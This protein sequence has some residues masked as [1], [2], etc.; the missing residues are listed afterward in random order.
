[1]PTHKQRKIRKIKKEIKRKIQNKQRSATAGTNNKTNNKMEDMLKMIMLMRNGQQQQST[2]AA[3]ELLTAKEM[4][5]KQQQEEARKQRENK[6]EISK[7]ELNNKIEDA[8]AKTQETNQTLEQTRKL[9]EIYKQIYEAEANLKNAKNELEIRK[10]QEKLNALNQQMEFENKTLDLMIQGQGLSENQ[11]ELK[12]EIEEKRGILKQKEV[13]RENKIQQLDIKNMESEKKQVEDKLLENISTIETLAKLTNRTGQIYKSVIND[14]KEYLKYLSGNIID[15]LTEI[16]ELGDNKKALKQ[17]GLE[18]KLVNA[19][20]VNTALIK[21][22]NELKDQLAGFAELNKQLKEKESD[23]NKIKSD[24]ASLAYN[25]NIQKYNTRPNDRGGLDIQV[26][27][28][29]K[30]KDGKEKETTKWIS[31]NDFD[32]NKDDPVER[33]VQKE[34]A[35]QNVINKQQNSIKK[36]QEAEYDRNERD[37][38]ELDKLKAENRKI[39]A[40]NEAMGNVQYEDKS[41]EIAQLEVAIQDA[42]DKINDK[43]CTKADYNKYNRKIEELKRKREELIKQNALIPKRDITDQQITE[44]TSLESD[45]ANHQDEINKKKANNKLY[46]E[47]NA[48]TDEIK[49]Q[50]KLKKAENTGLADKLNNENEQQIIRE[51]VAAEKEAEYSDAVRK[52]IELENIKRVKELQINALRS[53]EIKASEE[54]I[55]QELVKQFETE[56]KNKQLDRLHNAQEVSIEKT[57]ELKSRMGFNPNLANEPG[58]SQNTT[59]LLVM[60]DNIES[61]INDIKNAE[62]Y[63]K[64]HNEMFRDR[65]SKDS[66]LLEHVKNVFSNHEIDINSDEWYSD[67]LKTRMQVNLFN[68]VVEAVYNA[69]DSE[70]KIWNEE[71]LEN[72]ADIEKNIQNLIE[73]EQ[74]SSSV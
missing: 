47:F 37:V 12:H 53:D 16:K 21:A 34:L 54:K 6:H 51:R 40:Y 22:Q 41:Q 56:Y 31:V 38:L 65:L 57:A 10:A 8:K 39:N 32:I 33:D 25:L 2:T 44:R 70:N 67:N 5:A 15:K 3:N 28:Y 30:G 74:P 63:V 52:N 26:Y 50:D 48:K 58:I 23:N 43:N 4:M 69:Y 66:A 62:K 45:I 11:I 27:R 68:N 35:E 72:N 20:K 71:L 18:T 9:S 59:N 64:E 17:I 19:N 49:L 55:Q 73:T 36:Q 24:N 13:E 60:N 46:D 1:M 29:Y 61:T 42:K 7:I 14:A